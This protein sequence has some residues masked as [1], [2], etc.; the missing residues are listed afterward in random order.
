LAVGLNCNDSY[1]LVIAVMSSRAG[2]EEA[3]G[4]RRWMKTGMFYSTGRKN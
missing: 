2:K 3:G 4:V 1:G